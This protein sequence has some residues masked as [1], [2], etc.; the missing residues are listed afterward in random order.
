MRRFPKLI[1][2]SPQ[3]HSGFKAN[4]KICYF[5]PLPPDLPS[6]F[7]KYKVRALH[8]L[9]SYCL[10]ENANYVLSGYS[11]TWN[12]KYLMQLMPRFGVEEKGK[13]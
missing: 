10:R 5:N 7:L 13:K 9:T 11:K 12:S 3:T 6:F 2:V 8:T 1:A 4:K